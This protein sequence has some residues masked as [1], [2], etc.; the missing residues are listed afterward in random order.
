MGEKER[1][2]PDLALRESEPLPSRPGIP[3]VEIR[4]AR[5][6]DLVLLLLRISRFASSMGFLLLRLAV[7]RSVLPAE[8]RCAACASGF[9]PS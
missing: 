7:A 3:S 9:Q 8:L 6:A 1:R 5:C 2:S 4:P